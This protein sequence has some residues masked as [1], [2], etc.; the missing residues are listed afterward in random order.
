MSDNDVLNVAIREGRG[1]GAARKLR[2][3][4]QTP[5]VL[6]GHGEKTVNLSVGAADLTSFVRRGQ[7]LAKLA[8]AVSESALVRELQWDAMGN[9]IL[10]VD[11]TRVNVG[12]MVE[13]T[14]SV[15][16]RGEAPGVRV[17]GVVQHSLHEI[18]IRC[19]VQ[20]IPEKLVVSVSGL[21]LGQSLTLAE[22]ELPEGGELVGDGSTVF[23]QCVEAAAEVDEEASVADGAEPEVIG[24]KESDE[25]EEA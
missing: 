18:T 25:E 6:Y 13:T 10:H 11:F 19:P 1:S 17:G 22:I 21:E 14:V 8:G 12:E 9:D 23:V 2:A 4:G 7:K 16:L 3:S 5:A 24:R 20:N 15:E